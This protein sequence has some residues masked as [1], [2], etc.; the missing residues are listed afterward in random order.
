MHKQV[1]IGKLRINKG[2]LSNRIALTTAALQLK[3]TEEKMARLGKGR[4]ELIRLLCIHTAQKNAR[5]MSQYQKMRKKS[6]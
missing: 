1:L 3:K 6:K 5:T 4:K 2:T